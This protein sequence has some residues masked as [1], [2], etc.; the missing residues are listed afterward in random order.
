MYLQTKKDRNFD[1]II[2]LQSLKLEVPMLC[3]V[4]GCVSGH[5]DRRYTGKAMIR[6][7]AI[8]AKSKCS[9]IPHKSKMI[10]SKQMQKERQFNKRG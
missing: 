1:T 8:S 3:L 7:S 2:N 6:I 4:T 5:R 10:N 9:T